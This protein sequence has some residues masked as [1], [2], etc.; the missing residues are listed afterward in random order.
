LLLPF[1][2]SS[3]TN[4]ESGEEGSRWA[5]DHTWASP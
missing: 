3:S 2:L 4:H 1:T 5:G